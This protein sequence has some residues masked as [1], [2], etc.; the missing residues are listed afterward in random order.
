MFGLLL[1][2]CGLGLLQSSLQLNLLSLQ[3]LPSLNK[4]AGLQ[5]ILCF[6]TIFF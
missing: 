5:Q 6:E 3:P 4:I 1:L 2:Q